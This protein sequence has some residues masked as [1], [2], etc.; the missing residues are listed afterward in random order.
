MATERLL[1]R[2]EIESGYTL[3]ETIMVMSIVSVLMVLT[4]LI[5]Q[6]FQSQKTAE[7]F[8]EA[9]ER[10]VLYAQQHA[11]SNKKGVMILFDTAKNQY[12]GVEGGIPAKRLFT[13]SYDSDIQITPATMD[14]RVQFN[15]EGGITA[16]G[17]M[18]VA[19]RKEKY[20][21]IF[22]M[23]MGRMNVEGL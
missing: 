7:L 5:I 9:L 16:S 21:M 6:P 3:T 10:D 20:R 15:S 14:A 17:T 13:V 22:Y 4:M 2:Q 11:I 1:R 18:N 12:I 8:F 23:G 19:Y